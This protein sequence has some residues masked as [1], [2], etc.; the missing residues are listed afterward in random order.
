VNA[1][2]SDPGLGQGEEFDLIRRVAARLGPRARGLG[3]DCATLRWPGGQ[4]VLSSDLSVEGVHFRREWLQ[5]V[6]IG[7]RAT[8]AAMSDLAAAGAEPIGVLA[9]VAVPGDERDLIEEIMTG[10]GEACSSVGAVVLGGDLSRADAVTID[11]CAVGSA[12]SPVGR[13]GAQ[14]GDLLWVTGHLGDARAAVTMWHSDREPPAD[15]RSAF[16]RPEPL[17]AAGRWLAANGATAMIDVSDGVAS[18]AGHIA[19]RSEVQA[20]VILEQLPLGPAVDEVAAMVGEHPA[21]FSAAGG[22]DYQ[23]LVALPEKFGAQ[24][25][26]AFREACGISLTNIGRI[27]QGG[28]VQLLLDG[29]PVRVAGYDHFG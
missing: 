11:V 4:L 2:P 1:D 23:L 8:A 7:W 13:G 19:A 12:D 27:E 3:D 10:V 6:E 25:A 18:D 5:P 24:D 20:T 21:V 15:A 22:E 26:G 14:P 28:G 9:S 29:V 16:A 17:I